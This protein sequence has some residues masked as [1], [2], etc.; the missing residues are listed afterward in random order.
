MK[1]PNKEPV[2]QG[3]EMVFST[4][5]LLWLFIVVVAVM[6]GAQWL[7]RNHRRRSLVVVEY[8]ENLYNCSRIL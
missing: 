1:K 5:A 4:L 3:Q 6:Y 7:W 2:V 8:G